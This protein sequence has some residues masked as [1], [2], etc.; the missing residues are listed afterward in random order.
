MDQRLPAVGTVDASSLHHILGHRLKTSDVN[1][2]HIADL[3]PGHQ[4]HQTP[5]TIG[6]VGG[7]V[8][9]IAPQDGIKNQLPHIAQHHA[10]D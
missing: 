4:N 2:H 9:V 3:L 8:G 10:T 1:D 6:G 7:Q 5:E